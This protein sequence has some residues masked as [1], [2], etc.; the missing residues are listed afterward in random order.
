MESA[1]GDPRREYLAVWVNDR[2]EGGTTN[3][4]ADETA[5]YGP[6]ALYF[7]GSGEVRFKQVKLKDLGRRVLP[8]EQISSR[9]RMQH[10]NDFYYGWSAAAAD[11]NHDGVLD[12]VLGSLLLSGP[13]LS[14]RLKFTSARPPT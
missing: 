9:F 2:P 12:I 6:V 13:R 3:G 8:D 5:N 14:C 10:I 11:I 7:G 4:Q 1:R